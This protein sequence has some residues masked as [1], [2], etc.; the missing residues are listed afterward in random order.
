MLRLIKISSPDDKKNYFTSQSSPEDLWVVSH[1][2]A[3]KW[4][5]DQYLRK[6][7]SISTQTVLRATEYWQWLFSINC[8]EWRTISESLI[9]AS[10]EDW[11]EKNKTP[12]QLSDI[13]M[14]YNFITQLSPILYSNQKPLFA[15]WLQ[16]DSLRQ[17]K[18]TD[19]YKQ[20]EVFQQQMLQKKWIG[21]PWLLSFLNTRETVYWGE[22]KSIHFDLGLDLQ[23]E[24]VDMILRIA[25]QTDVQVLVPNP[26]WVAEYSQQMSVYNR[27]EELAQ[28]IQ[29]IGHQ[30]P[31]SS[32][33][34]I[35][36]N[37]VLQEI[38]SVVSEIRQ[39]LDKGVTP[40]QI[41]IGT[42]ALE[43]YW[44]LLKSHLDVEGIP[45]N[46]RVVARAI[47]LPNVQVW[48]AR[49]QLLKEDFNQAQLQAV[50][51]L[52]ET[53]NS[54]V[55]YRE[56]KKNFTNLYAADTLRDF[57]QLQTSYSKNKLIKLADF[58]DLLYAQWENENDDVLSEIVDRLVK[59]MSLQDEL[60]F[61]IW[62]KYLELVISRYEIPLYKEQIDGIQC[63]GLN[64][65]DWH[66]C[67]YVFILGCEQKLL[68]QTQRSPLQME[69][70]FA[71]ER[72]LGFYLQKT[73]SHKT[74]FDL[75]WC[76][77]KSLLKNTIF[78]SES[79]FN[80]EPQLASHFWMKLHISN[81]E[82]A[83]NRRAFTRWDQL[84]A[85]RIQDLYKN[86]DWQEKEGT[87]LSQKII[88]DV[89]TEFYPTIKSP[90]KPRLSASQL[91]RLDQCGF[92]FFA[93]KILKLKAHE[94]YDLEIDPMYNGQILHAILEKLV[95]TY[96]SLQVDQQQMEEIY[97]SVLANMQGHLPLQA[98][99]RNEKKRQLNLIYNFIELEKEYRQHHP[100]V[101][102][103]GTEVP[104]DGFLT[105]KQQQ[106][107]WS[108]EPISDESYAF[109]GK[110]D[111]LDQDDFGN[112]A[113]I[114]YKTSK[115]ET[116]KGFSSWLA[117]S[118]FQ[119]SIYAQA[120]ENGLASSADS[121]K[122]VAAE[123][124]FLKNKKRGSGFIVDQPE[125]GFIG[126]EQTEKTI[127][128]EEKQ[129]HD[130]NL[131]EKL[132]ELLAQIEKGIFPP[133]P[134]DIKICEKCNWSALCR[135]PHL[136]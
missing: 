130:Q 3:K 101:K 49:L 9:Y 58:V 45:V 66:S 104:I 122:V 39:L 89:D 55:S 2:E 46:K 36:E 91:Q 93:E 34:T 62:L 13:E 69:D 32:L 41:A 30:A 135:A 4:I 14:F 106:I 120:M 11:F 100:R 95:L 124:I 15:E 126:L 133:K 85:L 113:I 50:L 94:E 128:I 82:G 87:L 24:E 132:K 88:M 118:Q 84:M 63:Y 31:A 16:Q 115:T 60:S 107:V 73:E 5:Q 96:P 25:K 112:F 108:K 42:A 12:T 28:E 44:P 76:L 121:K 86:L 129:K 77:Q 35:Q 40:A 116:V 26:Y 98:F 48:L 56:F 61:A 79:D 33:T 74:E 75:R 105:P 23:H 125:N 117:N 71:L 119:M 136:R 19:W 99:W 83:D 68:V 67:E 21:K 43:D 123:Y 72:D 38:K 70:L 29:T 7:K 131:Q 52:S 1:I 20:A 53:E 80:G 103:I 8:P 127:S 6:S 81:R 110:M 10:I 57:F 97:E 78:H 51:Y 37:S 54:K 134:K 65:M 114:D 111:R 90:Q 92:L 27:L 18:L 17:Q 22:F 64:A 109:S 47:A 59:D 102:T